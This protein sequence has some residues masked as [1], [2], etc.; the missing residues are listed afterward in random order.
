MTRLMIA[1]D[2]G[3]AA[4]VE[5]LFKEVTE[6]LNAGMQHTEASCYSTDTNSFTDFEEDGVDIPR[7]AIVYVYRDIGK[8]E[9][10]WDIYKFGYCGE[11]AVSKDN[12][13][14][15]AGLVNAGF[16]FFPF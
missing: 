6:V 16:D 14:D 9:A 2:E 13:G 11:Y 1:N 12:E 5:A 4:K 3:E 8:G 15:L 7:G 10:V